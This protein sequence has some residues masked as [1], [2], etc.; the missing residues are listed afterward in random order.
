MHKS[1]SLSAY[2]KKRN[3]VSLGASGSLRYMLKN[4]LGAGTFADFW[5]YWNPVWGYYLA[6]FVMRPLSRALPSSVATMLTFSVSGFLHDVAVM[7]IKLQPSF[8]LTLWFSV[9]GSAVV[10]T[11]YAQLSYR[12]VIWPIRAL[13]NLS[14]VASCYWLSTILVN[15]CSAFVQSF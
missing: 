11:S 5:R 4:S 6:K 14:I 10:L 7:L 3:G 15:V 1:I 9:M 12:H 13:A 8:V 2:V